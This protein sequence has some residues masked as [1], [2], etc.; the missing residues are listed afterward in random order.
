MRSLVK[1][2]TA[3]ACVLWL[4]ALLGCL[5]DRPTALEADGGSNGA[6][7]VTGGVGG[8]GGASGGKGSAG[9][10]GGS[11]GFG[12]AA[13]QKGTGTGGV[14]G[15]GGGGA[16]GAG[17]GGAS[18]GADS[19]CTNLA[20]QCSGASLQTCGSDGVWGTPM[21]CPMH[22]ACAGGVG[23]AACACV[24]EPDCAVGGMICQGA[25]LLTCSLDSDGCAYKSASATCA[26]GA[27]TGD[28]GTASCC[29]NACVD[30]ATQCLSVTS[31]QTCAP[32]ANGCTVTSMA[33]CSTGLV[34]ERG[35]IPGCVDP[36]WAEWPMPNMAV[37]SGGAPNI[38][39]YTDNGDGSI[40]DNI[41]GLM[42]QK[43]PTTD[44]WAD[45]INYCA[46]LNLAGHADWRMPSF[47]ELLSLVDYNS[48][49]T[50]NQTYFPKVND[51]VWSSTLT[52]GSTDRI[53]LDP[54]E[55]QVFESNLTFPA[56]VL[57]VR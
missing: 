9:T 48:S 35:G 14:T 7:G 55:G 21:T 47:I 10:A 16:T 25:T 26:N 54:S 19:K 15:T 50:L 3:S 42:W 17:G 53:G 20:T 30:G 11:S 39:S 37:D 33:D 5:G 41:T 27:C 56:Q 28:P 49:P 23:A 1:G 43:D 36:N 22:Q 18:G 44:G 34:C 45:G 4:S 2:G 31:L 38:A 13:G 8:K 6:A 40:S 46:T 52:G 57:C 32:V 29:T 24:V 12:G 51:Y